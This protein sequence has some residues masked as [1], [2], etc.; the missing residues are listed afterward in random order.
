MRSVREAAIK[1]HLDI[2]C[3]PQEARSFFGLPDLDPLQ[4]A[5]VARLQERMMAGLDSLDPE[6]LMKTWLPTTLQNWDQFQ[7]AFWS[8][9]RDATRGGRSEG[10]A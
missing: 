9:A 5:L 4:R 7:K 3:T 1:I 6:A 8:M 2:D 10:P